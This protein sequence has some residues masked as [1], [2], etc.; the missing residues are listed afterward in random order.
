MSELELVVL[1]CTYNHK[2]SIAKAIESVLAQKTNFKFQ[3]WIL[4]DCSTDGT[5]DIVREYANKYPEIIVPFINEVNKSASKNTFE[6]LKKMNAKYFATLDGD[7]YWTDE[8]KLQ[9][10][11]DILENNPDCSFCAHNTLKKYPNDEKNMHNNEPYIKTKIK[12]GKY[13]FPKNVKKEYLEP[14]LSSRVYR[15]SCLNLDKVDDPFIISYDT[16]ITFWFLQFGNLYYIDKIMSVYN[17]TYQ[18]IYTAKNPQQKLY[19]GANAINRI[20]KAL[21]YKYNK[22]FLDFFKRKIPL[23]LMQYLKIK[24]LTDKETLNNLY[25]KILDKYIKDENERL[26][27]KILKTIKL[28]LSKRK[29]LCLDIRREK[30][31]T[32]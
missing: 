20:N 10:Q 27:S 22:M 28:P 4:D 6:A 13:H 18:G 21:D 19:M 30:K 24:H 5:S 1:I 7:D 16:A 14:H 12:S 17:Y 15:T 9:I 23:S 11:V 2:N 25:C 32:L 8:N 26:N 3:A 31:E 29:I